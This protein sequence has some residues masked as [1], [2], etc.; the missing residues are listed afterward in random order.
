MLKSQT[1]SCDDRM[2]APGL[3]VPPSLPPSAHPPFRVSALRPFSGPQLPADLSPGPCSLPPSHP[4]PGPAPPLQTRVRPSPR[5]PSSFWPV[6]WLPQLLCPFLAPD[7]A[8]QYLAPPGSLL[9]SDIS[10]LCPPASGWTL[11]AS[12]GASHVVYPR[13]SFVSSF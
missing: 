13:L 10:G 2:G 6:H 8:A 3:L 11:S 9:C 1:V 5:L 4:L 12:A 7:P